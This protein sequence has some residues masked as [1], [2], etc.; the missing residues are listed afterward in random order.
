MTV[1]KLGDITEKIILKSLKNL[2][3]E[4]IL[5]YQLSRNWKNIIGEN[6]AKMVRVNHLTND[7][8]L[9]LKLINICYSS[10]VNSYK[11][12]I[13]ERINM[14]LGGDYISKIIIIA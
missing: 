10:E 8:S 7:G 3:R 11:T 12:L 1:K 9:M 6:I 2:G 4:Y 14:Y 5:T 13:L